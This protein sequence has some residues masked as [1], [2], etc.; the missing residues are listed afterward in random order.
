[1]IVV[2]CFDVMQVLEGIFY[3]VLWIYFDGNVLRNLI[4]LKEVN[5]GSF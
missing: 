2:R 1:M 4:F 3:L 5:I